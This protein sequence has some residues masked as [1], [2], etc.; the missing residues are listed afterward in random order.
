MRNHSLLLHMDGVI[1][2]KH[3]YFQL[4]REFID[5]ILDE[6]RAI[7]ASG[8]KRLVITTQAGIDRGF[9]SEQQFQQ[10]TTSMCVE[11]LN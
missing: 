3:S 7:Q 10:L 5:G 2:F 8:Y 4:C 11:F 9:Y 6:V 1:N